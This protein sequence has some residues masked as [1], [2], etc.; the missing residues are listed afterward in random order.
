MY[1]CQPWWIDYLFSWENIFKKWC[2]ATS[3]NLGNSSES[4]RR[5]LPQSN[6]LDVP[7]IPRFL[8]TNHLLNAY[9]YN[10]TLVLVCRGALNI[11]KM[12]FEDLGRYRSSLLQWL[13]YIRV[14]IDG[15]TT[16]KWCTK[17]IL[18]CEL[19]T[20]TSQCGQY[21]FSITMVS[22]YIISYFSTNGPIDVI[23]DMKKSYINIFC[24]R[25]KKPTLRL[26]LWKT[27]YYVKKHNV[28]PICPM[29]I[30]IQHARRL[31]QNQQQHG[32]AA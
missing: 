28:S 22:N 32:L 1:S 24:R 9:V 12:T 13:I 21:I 26:C 20:V 14:T 7:S 29:N 17:G 19:P 5:A 27:P 15:A 2:Q 10:N 11:T 16:K 8:F 23:Q 31:L 18:S 6:G 30:S 3:S 25:G 4:F